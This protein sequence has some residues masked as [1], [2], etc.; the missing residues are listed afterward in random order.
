ML[1]DQDPP[2]LPSP[3]KTVQTRSSLRQHDSM[4]SARHKRGAASSCHSE[5]DLLTSNLSPRSNTIPL[6]ELT[7]SMDSVKKGESSVFYSLDNLD[8]L[9]RRSHNSQDAAAGRQ[10]NMNLNINN[11]SLEDTMLTMTEFKSLNTDEKHQAVMRLVPL[12]K[13]FIGSLNDNLSR[14]E[15]TVMEA[16]HHL[17][18]FSDPPQYNSIVQS[19]LTL[20]DRPPPHTSYESACLLLYYADMIQ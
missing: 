20:T 1:K 19:K 11:L 16:H 13:P 7:N 18:S 3:A 10:W 4:S 9:G 15:S 8:G 5:D 6:I 12:L 2:L 14:M 17:D